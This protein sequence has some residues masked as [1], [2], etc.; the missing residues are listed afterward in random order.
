MKYFDIAIINI[1]LFL[2]FC[3][4]PW[5]GCQVLARGGL[6]VITG[7][8]SFGVLAGGMARLSFLGHFAPVIPSGVRGV[9]LKFDRAQ[10]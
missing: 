10:S 7:T 8:P 5:L 6:T 9:K 4:F 1:I 2:Q 3:G